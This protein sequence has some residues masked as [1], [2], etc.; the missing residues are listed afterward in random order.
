M[1]T[2]IDMKWHFQVVYFYCVIW[3]N[4]GFTAFLTTTI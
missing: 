3:D 4:V 2:E 1:S